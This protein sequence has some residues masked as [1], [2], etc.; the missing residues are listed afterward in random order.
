MLRQQKEKVYAPLSIYVFQKKTKKI[1][2]RNVINTVICIGIYK[3]S[4]TTT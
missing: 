2:G 4:Y 1:K 3:T